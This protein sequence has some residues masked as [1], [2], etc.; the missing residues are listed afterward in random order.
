[1]TKP[2][3][4]AGVKT[5]KPALALPFFLAREVAFLAETDFEKDK[6]Q[7]SGKSRRQQGDREDFAG[8]PLDQGGT[9]GACQH[10]HGG[11]SKRDDAPPRR[12]VFNLRMVPRP[13]SA[14]R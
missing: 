14:K 6:E 3:A 13:R 10:Q 7:G 2:R 1:M 11:R 12:H 4:P 8:H 5:S 9:R